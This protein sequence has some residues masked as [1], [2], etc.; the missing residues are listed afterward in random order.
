MRFVCSPPLMVIAVNVGNGVRG[1]VDIT[2]LPRI[3]H[4]GSLP[5]LHVFN[6]KPARKCRYIKDFLNEV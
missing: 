4:L 3:C 1:V 6:L 2:D 5:Y